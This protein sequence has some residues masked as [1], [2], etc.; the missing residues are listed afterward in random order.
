MA[1]KIPGASAVAL[2]SPVWALVLLVEL[3]TA[4]GFAAHLREHRAA[5][6]ATQTIP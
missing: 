5:R 1:Q 4:I 6:V 3:K 2:G